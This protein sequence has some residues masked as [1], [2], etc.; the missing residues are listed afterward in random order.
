MK[1]P[2]TIPAV[3]ILMILL[4]AVCRT[5]M[6]T[7][8]QT[9]AENEF[10]LIEETSDSSLTDSGYE[11]TGGGGVIVEMQN[12]PCAKTARNRA[13][14]CE[15]MFLCSNERIFRWTGVAHYICEN[16]ADVDNLVR[17]SGFLGIA[18]ITEYGQGQDV[19]SRQLVGYTL[20]EAEGRCDGTVIPAL[21]RNQQFNCH[22]TIAEGGCTTPGFDGSCPPGTVDNGFG[23]CCTTS[24]EG[25]GLICDVFNLSGFG[26]LCPSPVLVD[27]FGDG[28]N[29][30]DA[31]HG[32]AFDLNNDGVTGALAWTSSGSDDAWLVLDRNGN[33]RI[34]NGAELFGNFTPQPSNDNP[35]GFLALAEYDK[36]ANGGNADGLIDA[37]DP[38]FSSLRLWQDDNHNGTSEAL[39]LHTLKQLGV[40]SISLDYKDSKRRDEFGNQFRYRAKVD[41]AKHS[42]VGRWAY[43]VFLV[44]Q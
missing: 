11:N 17:V 21:V 43:D 33:G 15:G 27:I 39:E 5:S 29:L 31:Q 19:L 16:G 36:S 44:S 3:M 32:I 38:I 12:I 9:G 4:G 35:N 2:L 13:A 23:M 42:R 8:A 26:L 41:D 6:R 34:D 40:N 37:T 22:S 7:S 14:I 28:F 24:P 30:T 25:G 20:T 18:G 10:T 1:N